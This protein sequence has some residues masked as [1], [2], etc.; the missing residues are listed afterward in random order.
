VHP[1]IAIFGTPPP[2]RPY[3]DAL[4]ILRWYLQ[5]F[6]SYRDDTQTH[7]RTLLKTVASSDSVWLVNAYYTSV[8]WAVER[9]VRVVSP[10]ISSRKCLEQIC[11]GK[12]PEIYSN[13]SGNFYFRKFSGTFTKNT[14]Q[15]FQKTVYL[16]TS[17]L[18]IGCFSTS[19]H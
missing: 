16:F 9:M 19:R 2:F 6:R 8:H 12:F 3:D 10:E 15:T 14:V 1:Y 4:I 5:W 7:K 13:L 11:S 18:S 17:S